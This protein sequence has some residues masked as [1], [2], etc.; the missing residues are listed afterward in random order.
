M[1]PI[2]RRL[3]LAAAGAPL[4]GALAWASA[5]GFPSKPITIVVPYPAGGIVD[6]VNRQ[7][8]DAAGR[9]TG[10]RFVIYNRPGGIGLIGA[11]YVARAR[12]TDT[13]SCRG[14]AAS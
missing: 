4:A 6:V 8:A 12:P 5:Q 14:R 10:H 3:L 11:D 13:P 2:R 7:I 9:L 1:N